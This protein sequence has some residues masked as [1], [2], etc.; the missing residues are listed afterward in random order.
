M[1]QPC[2]EIGMRQAY[3]GG[4]HGPQRGSVREEGGGRLVVEVD[5]GRRF[6]AAREP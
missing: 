2:R 4:G 1:Q 5:G 3:D 6:R